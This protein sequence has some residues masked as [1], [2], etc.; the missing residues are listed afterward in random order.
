MFN[1]DTKMSDVTPREVRVYSDSKGERPF[2][3]WRRSLR[4]RRA[5]TKIEKRLERLEEGNLGDTKSVGGGVF[6]L[7]IDY[8][9]GYRIYFGHVSE[10]IIVL[11]CGGDKSTQDEDILRARQY[12][13]DYRGRKSGV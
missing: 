12:L 10:I 11:L 1:L 9:P 5:V 7:R 4:D 3:N 6:E 8:G 2:T 13:N